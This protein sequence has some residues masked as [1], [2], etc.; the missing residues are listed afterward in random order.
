[1]KSMIYTIYF[2][3]KCKKKVIF[4]KNSS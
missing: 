1:M 3:K 2:L 4:V